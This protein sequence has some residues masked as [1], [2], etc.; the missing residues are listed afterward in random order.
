MLNRNRLLTIIVT[1]LIATSCKKAVEQ[2]TEN[3]LQQYFEQNILNRDFKVVRAI[4]DTIHNR[5]AEYSSYIFR[6]EKNTTTNS[7]T[8]GPMKATVN[9]TD[10]C[11]GT[12]SCTEDYGKLGINLTIPT[13]PPSFT[14]INRSW[15][16]TEKA[17]P[18]M[19]LA[20]WG[21]T[22]HD[23]LYMERQ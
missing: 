22:A 8:D 5:T 18:V 19:K 21:T 20:P 13:T 17:F 16:F 11:T 4:D 3:I 10:V 14:F 7:N 12:W 15:K 23:T 6:L 1:L 2:K 9:G